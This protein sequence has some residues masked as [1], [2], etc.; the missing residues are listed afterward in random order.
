MSDKRR[1]PRVVRQ[2]S[3]TNEAILGLSVKIVD[4]RSN[5]GFVRQNSQTNEAILGLSDKI[6][7]QTEKTWVC[8]TK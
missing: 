4:K 6:V 2:N 5:T 8:Q 1:K 3:Q 7:R